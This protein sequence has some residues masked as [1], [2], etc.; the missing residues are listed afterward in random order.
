MKTIVELEFQNF[1]SA[2]GLNP[3][4]NSFSKT[5]KT[6]S[7]RIIPIE[8]CCEKCGYII[9]FKTQN[10]EKHLRSN[11]SNLTI[12]DRRISERFSQEKKY[13]FVD[14]YCPKCNQATIIFYDGGPSGYWGFFQMEI[15][16]IVVI[17]NEL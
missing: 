5:E 4:P 8:Y 16:K 11:F 1:L 10:F 9:S 15:V 12:E 6:V 2:T 17:K 13:S 7:D 3:S 14:F